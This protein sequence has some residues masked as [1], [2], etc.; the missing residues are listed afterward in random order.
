MS[1]LAG[2]VCTL[3]NAGQASVGQAIADPES[4]KP[5][6]AAYDLLVAAG[7]QPTVTDLASQLPDYKPYRELYQ[8]RATTLATQVGISVQEAFGFEA[9][10]TEGLSFSQPLLRLIDTP[11]GP[12]TVLLTITGDK[13]QFAANLE[14]GKL[15]E[16]TPPKALGPLQDSLVRL[17]RHPK[18]DARRIA[19]CEKCAAFFYRPRLNST[20]CSRPC[21]D[22]LQSQVYYRREKERRDRAIALHQQGKDL[23]EI[24]R[25]LELESRGSAKS[26]TNRVRHYL[27]QKA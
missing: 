15:E 16:I 5:L 4:H 8:Q 13:T 25:E 20:A 23:K 9:A 14:T 18:F 27:A 1:E 3:A 6:K 12:A 2:I 11:P 17:L 24:A 7:W 10:L 26:P 19:I 22:A 21:V